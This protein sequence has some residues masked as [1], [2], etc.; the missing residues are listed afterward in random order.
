MAFIT[1]TFVGENALQL[2]NEEFIR[3]FNFGSQWSRIRIGLLFALSTPPSIV[4]GPFFSARN[5]D[6][7]VGVCQGPNSGYSNPSPVDCLVSMPFTLNGFINNLTTYWSAPCNPCRNI[8]KYG[9]SET[10]S[11][12]SGGSMWGSL[13]PN[14]SQLFFDFTIQKTRGALATFYAYGPVSIAQASQVITRYEF[15]TN[16]QC[17]NLAGIT[18]VGQLY[19]SFLAY[20]G[21]FNLNC[22][23]I[24]WRRSLPTLVISELSVIRYF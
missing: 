16:M 17:D 12:Q 2:G 7:S 13:P 4:T 18:N 14:K 10:S 8:W 15:M 21:N 5:S 1:Q 23:C 22:I 20:S 19:G 6:L 9:N 24:W 3:P 11:S